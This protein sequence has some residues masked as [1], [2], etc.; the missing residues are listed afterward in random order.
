M[1]AEWAI[2]AEFDYTGGE[3][4]YTATT[5]G[6]YK[7]EVWGAKGGDG[8]STYKG[9]YGAYSNGT[10]KLLKSDVLFVNVGGNG[11]TGKS[12]TGGYNGGGA[13]GNQESTGGSGGGATHISYRTGLLAELVDNKNLVLIVSGGGGGGGYY[14]DGNYGYGGHAGGYIGSNGTSTK[15]TNRIGQGGT[16]MLGGVVEIRGDVAPYSGSFGQGGTQLSGTT[17]I[18]G[19]GGAGWFGGSFGGDYGAG[20]GGGSGYIGNSLLTD[21]YM[22]CYNCATSD[23]VD[24]KTYTTKCAEETP[25]E[26]CAKIGNGYAKI[27]FIGK[28]ID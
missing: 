18:S 8:T 16:Q 2:N 23:A 14:S 19:G 24:T 5:D 6:Y 10:I 15:A 21:K 9:G 25:T 1:T 7:L 4:T 17:Q 11:Q 3:Q 27:T 12:A 26:N 22:Y 13:S 28:T 20:G